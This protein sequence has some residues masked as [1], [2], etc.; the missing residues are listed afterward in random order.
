[1]RGLQRVHDDVG[2]AVQLVGRA[3]A[4]GPRRP[5]V[6]RL[7]DA[8]R[9][10][11]RC[12]RAVAATPTAQRGHVDVV[13]VGRVDRD[14]GRG[15][16]GEPRRHVPPVEAAVGAAPHAVAVVRVA[17]QRALAGA[18]VDDLVVARRHREGAHRLGVGVVGARGPPPVRGVVG[19]H[20]ALGRAEEDR[21]VVAHREGADPSAHRR[22]GVRG[23]HHLDD[24][25][26]SDGGPGAAA[27]RAP[28]VLAADA[29]GGAAR[30]VSELGRLGDRQGVV[31][32]EQAARVVGVPQLVEALLVRAVLVLALRVEQHRRVVRGGGGGRRRRGG[33]KDRRHETDAESG[34][35][36]TGD[37]G[38]SAH[39]GL[40]RA[41]GGEFP[42]SISSRRQWV[43]SGEPTFIES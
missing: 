24:G 40:R 31:A 15:L 1:M 12:G 16:A 30:G 36:R 22:E 29:G 41:G 11:R 5:A 35:E 20:P 38:P 43:T 27:G 32:R 28:V 2:R 4:Q 25:I 37:E 19:P 7:P 42:G 13:R 26:G 18:Q 34:D 10:R 33:G 14:R 39:G 6:A 9:R 23:A 21:A 3:L 17:G 8:V